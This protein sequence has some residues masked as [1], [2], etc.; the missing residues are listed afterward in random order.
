MNNVFVI[1]EAGVNHN[2][3][4]DIAR[5]LIDAAVAAGADA[6]KFQ[7]FKAEK[8]VSKY[9]QKAEYQKQTTGNTESQLEMIKRFELSYNDHLSLVD[10]CSKRGIKFLSTAFD[11]DSIDFLKTI[12]MAYWKIP[13]GEITNLPYLR[14]VGSIASKVLLSTGMASLGEVEAAIEVLSKSGMQRDN[15]TVLHCTTEYPAPFDEVNLKAMVTMGKAFSLAYGYSDHTEG[16]AIPIA[17]VAL[18]ASVVEKHFT[19]DKTMEGPD[20]KA[21]LEPRE[22]SEMVTAI[23]MVERA[24]GDGVKR[25]TPSESKNR[26]V[27]RKSIVAARKIAKGAV[28]T[29]ADITTKRPGNGIS[30]ME[31]DNVVGSVATR[32]YD[33]DEALQK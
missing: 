8:L 9:A 20:H 28:I 14:R 16:I 26:A 23:R 3:N 2:G 21:S 6:V 4:I 18:G 11:D 17:A 15:I 27:A 10:Y 7:T 33:I 13:S 12:K 30:P 32:D 1:A 25:V 5:K 22:L 19:L 31:W 29:E 24:L